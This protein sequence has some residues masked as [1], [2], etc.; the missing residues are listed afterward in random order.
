MRGHAIKVC[1]RGESHQGMLLVDSGP[2]T[3][4]V[5]KRNFEQTSVFRKMVGC[6]TSWRQGIHTKRFGFKNFRVLTVIASA[7]RVN[8]LLTANK[9]LSGGQARMAAP[10]GLQ[11]LRDDPNPRSGADPARE[12]A[13]RL[14]ALKELA[15][16]LDRE[17][18]LL[19]D[20]GQRAALEVSAAVIGHDYLARA[21]VLVLEDV[22]AATDARHKK[23]CFAQGSNHVAGLESRQTRN[24]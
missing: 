1:R 19:D 11:R 16:L 21:A 18:G 2:S 20:R 14:L 5:V 15:K 4:A 24:S 17:S 22:V 12:C 10:G 9:K 8:N 7:N 13:L 6:H 3:M 23:P